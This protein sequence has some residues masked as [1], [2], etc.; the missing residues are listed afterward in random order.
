MRRRWVEFAHNFLDT[1]HFGPILLCIHREKCQ[2]FI[3]E[4][5]WMNKGVFEKVAPRKFDFIRC[6][7]IYILS[8]LVVHLNAIAPIAHKQPVH[9]QSALAQLARAQDC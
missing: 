8:N 6:R 2:L 3:N 7:P 9:A 5:I 4:E 1:M